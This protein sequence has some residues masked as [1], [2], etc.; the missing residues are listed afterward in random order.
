[1]C[2]LFLLVCKHVHSTVFIIPELGKT[3]LSSSLF[4]HWWIFL[5]PG[6]MPNFFGRVYLVR[7]QPSDWEKTLVK[8]AGL[9]PGKLEAAGGDLAPEDD[10]P[11]PTSGTHQWV[12]T[13][14]NDSSLN[15]CSQIQHDSFFACTKRSYLSFT[16][17]FQK[18]EIT[19]NF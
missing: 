8:T 17:G 18:R 6:E 2:V 16:F 4:E 10:R 11:L 3:K 1:M 19:P 13:P 14:R 7:P 5:D 15:T 12:L 9:R